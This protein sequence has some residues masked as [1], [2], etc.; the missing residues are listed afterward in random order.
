[1][2]DLYQYG[3]RISP[4]SSHSSLSVT[5]KPRSPSPKRSQHSSPSKRKPLHER[6]DSETNEHPTIRLVK[7]PEPVDEPDSPIYSKNPF[8]SKPSHVLPPGSS[9]KRVPQDRDRHVS[10]AAPPPNPPASSLRID[11]LF[12]APLHPKTSI[13]GSTPAIPSDTG[14]RHDQGPSYSPSSSRF[15]SAPSLRHSAPANVQLDTSVQDENEGDDTAAIPA[16][17]RPILPSLISK[18]DQ[19][20]SSRASDTSFASSDTLDTLTTRPHHQA[21]PAGSLDADAGAS[22]TSLVISERNP[23]RPL[24]ARSRGSQ[25]SITTPVAYPRPI[26]KR[27]AE[28]IASR[29]LLSK[30][31]IERLRSFSNP[32]APWHAALQATLNSGVRVQYPTVKPP[33]TAG[34][35]ASVE[36]ETP[37]PINIPKRRSTRMNERPAAHPPW[38]TRPLS[39]IPSES[40]RAFTE[41]SGV[42]TQGS[43]PIER[44]RTRGSLGS[45]FMLNA[46]PEEFGDLDRRLGKQPVRQDHEEHHDTVGELS[47]PYMR[48]HHSGSLL[49]HSDP[50]LRPESALSDYQSR[51]SSYGSYVAATLPDWAKRYYSLGERTSLIIT[52]LPNS[53][54]TSLASNRLNTANTDRSGSPDA[55]NLP[56]SI[57]HPRKRPH[58]QI[59]ATP[60]DEDISTTEGDPSSPAGPTP[61][62]SPSRPVHGSHAEALGSNPHRERDSLAITE[63]PPTQ[64]A[65]ER[66]SVLRPLEA[67]RVSHPFSPH[68]R[69]DRRSTA[70]GISRR[71]AYRL[72]AWRAPS[73]EEVGAG[74]NWVWSPEGRQVVL[75]AMGFL[76]PLAWMVGA[77]LPLPKLREAEMSEIR[78]GLSGGGPQ[79]RS[80]LDVEAAIVQEVGSLEE[81]KYQKAKWWR[82]ANRIMSVVGL[83]VIGV[84]IA[85]VEVGVHM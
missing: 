54:S 28:S 67:R 46:T 27:S 63:T 9:H 11:S 55:S 42:T 81:R 41:G 4:M 61:S 13:S 12:P 1:M 16:D 2:H 66:L 65:H 44:R 17:I 26:L 52:G 85:L 39:T 37:P 40:E 32:S 18:L 60:P 49:R 70:T 5:S 68:L 59:P 6:T 21:N 50:L 74:W 53:S 38:G 75:F 79:T 71:S 84:I 72:S 73:L 7:Y 56:L 3:V 33:S 47:S 36:N 64:P 23:S 25:R 76:F 35:W 45:S 22:A 51:R 82:W 57:F 83:V 29:T 15:P 69:P 58:V 20:L 43:S 10:D 24:T 8:P 34:S 30:A 78:R 77:V 80:Q 14:S 19:E 31:S 62:K 48:T